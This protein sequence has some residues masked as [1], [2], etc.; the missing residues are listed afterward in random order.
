MNPILDVMNF[1]DHR[2]QRDIKSLIEC[3]T[4]CEHNFVQ[5][6]VQMPRGG[7]LTEL[8]EVNNKSLR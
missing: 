5:T 7:Q 2:S 3:G 1:N 6:S 8:Q 4:L